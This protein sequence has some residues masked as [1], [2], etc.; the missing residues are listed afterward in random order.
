MNTSTVFVR[1]ASLLAALALAACSKSPPQ[2]Y[3]VNLSPAFKVGQKFSLVSDLTER[4]GSHTV[5][6]LPGIASPQ[7]D[8]RSEDI[9]AHL[10]GD[11]E[12]LGIYPNGG[13]QKLSLTIKV[14]KAS[15]DGKTVSGLPAAGVKIVAAT[16]GEQTAISVDGKAADAG[17]T[18]IFNELLDLHEEKLPPQDLFGANTPEPVGGTWPVNSSAVEASLKKSSGG[19]VKDIKGTMK[20]AAVTGT[21]ASQVLEVSGEISVASLKLP[22]PAV[23]TIDSGTITSNLSFSIPVATSGALKTSR[24]MAMKT[25]GHGSPNGA[26]VKTEITGQ[27]S[28]QSIL[29]FQ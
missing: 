20:L 8:D 12:V 11:A 1:F 4:T 15:K 7:N 19:E 14:V 28:Y 10:E 5:I 16:E 17:L 25:L 29:T 24:R 23:I 18:Q 26:T 27:Q 21:G 13:I 22:L 3:P 9:A 2:L 6:T